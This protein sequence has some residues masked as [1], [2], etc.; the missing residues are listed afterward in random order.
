MT[1][2]LIRFGQLVKVDAKAYG[3]FVEVHPQRPEI[4]VELLTGQGDYGSTAWFN[5]DQIEVIE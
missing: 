1:P 2:G 5:F 3:L 4:R